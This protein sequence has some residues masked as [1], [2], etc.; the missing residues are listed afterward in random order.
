[1]K[2]I[3]LATVLTAGFACTAHA[4]MV[5]VGFNDFDASPEF[6]YANY[7]SA[8]SMDPWQKCARSYG[9]SAVAISSETLCTYETNYARDYPDALLSDRALNDSGLLTAYGPLSITADGE[10]TLS[11]IDV[12][13][14]L[15]NH[16]MSLRFDA[17]LNGALTSSSDV[18][19]PAADPSN[20]AAWVGGQSWLFGFNGAN[21]GV[22]DRLVISGIPGIRGDG[23]FFLDNLVVDAV[24]VP[25]P[26]TMAL[27]A[28]GG[29]GLLAGRR[30]KTA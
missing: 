15:N 16:G 1:M 19:F 9:A 13:S 28:L 6:S 11:S 25:E 8:G 27:F 23:K 20:Y 7:Q 12:L 14:G 17:Y 5:S 3:V 21:L 18:Y 24:N 22:M 4:G 26:G 29:L 2:R 10:F 30:R